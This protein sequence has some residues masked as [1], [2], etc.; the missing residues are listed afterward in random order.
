M[1]QALA[2]HGVAV[3]KVQRAG[4]THEP[5]LVRTQYSLDQPQK[6]RHAAN[7]DDHGD[8]APERAFQH[9]IAEPRRGEGCNGKIHC[10]N[11]ITDV[12]VVPRLCLVD[13]LRHNKYEEQRLAALI[14][15]SSYFLKN[16]KSCRRRSKVAGTKQSEHAERTQKRQILSDDR[17]KERKL[18][19]CLRCCKGLS[20]NWG[21][22]WLIYTRAEKSI[23]I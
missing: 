13:Q 9:N 1:P 23:R 22:F 4:R 20:R 12:F 10:V 19:A 2:M 11:E 15:I 8:K 14:C 17:H 3:V 7:H 5:H 21:R 18:P 6:Q 16:G